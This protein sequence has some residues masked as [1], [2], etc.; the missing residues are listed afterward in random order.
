MAPQEKVLSVKLD[1]PSSIPE[2]T[3]WNKRTDVSKCPLTSTHM[4]GHVHTPK[5]PSKS[6]NNIFKNVCSTGLLLCCHDRTL[7]QTNLGGGH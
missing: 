4:L 2:P 6:L 1:D 5:L 3:Q 7:T